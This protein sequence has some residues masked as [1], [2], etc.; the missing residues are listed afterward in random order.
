MAGSNNVD[1]YNTCIVYQTG[2]VVCRRVNHTSLGSQRLKSQ[3]RAGFGEIMEV[4]LTL[5]TGKK[6]D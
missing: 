2:Q 3:G 1:H 5:V 6:Q 4:E